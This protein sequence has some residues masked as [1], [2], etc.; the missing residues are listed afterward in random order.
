MDVDAS[1]A[2]VDARWGRR[3]FVVTTVAL[4]LPLAMMAVRVLAHDWPNPG[5]DIAL[6][7]LRTRD[8]GA[9]TP[10]LGS[11]GRYGFSQPGPLWFYALALPY[12]VFGSRFAGLQIGVLVA[13]VA[14]VLA[15]LTVARRRGGVVLMMI[16]AA[17]L[18]V[19]VHGLGALWLADPWE[20]HGLTLL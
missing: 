4:M 1:D 12:R 13:N 20:P 14:A 5:G 15:M 2:D 9:H 17:L 7:E 11:Y 3:L 8:V 16:V 6:I 18:G 10:L 19:L